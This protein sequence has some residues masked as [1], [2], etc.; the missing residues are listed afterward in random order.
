[1]QEEL[2]GT[3]DASRPL[4]V[5]T[6]TFVIVVF[7]VVF[8]SGVPRFLFPPL[9]LTVT[10]AVI[11]SYL[12][13]IMVIPALAAKLLK[14]SPVKANGENG[15]DGRPIVPSW[16]ENIFQTV[17]R[18]RFVVV[19]ASFGLLIVTGFV[20]ATMGTELFPPV[21]SKQFTIYVRT[22]S[23]TRIEKTERIVAAIEN[24]IIDELG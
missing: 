14:S 10:F 24:S 22:P 23:G 4:L 19:L 7:P 17:M 2:E 12:I 16:F 13:A 8:L 1:M 20:V 15:S 5:S 11:A 6:V 18:M 21:D 9:A 3:Q